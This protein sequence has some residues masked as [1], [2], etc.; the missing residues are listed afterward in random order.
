[1]VLHDPFQVGVSLGETNRSR[2]RAGH[3]NEERVEILLIEDNAVIGDAIAGHLADDC[4]VK[5]FSLPDLSRRISR[6]TERVQ[7]S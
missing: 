5:P 6:L 3:G 4:L 2:I 1:M 7:R